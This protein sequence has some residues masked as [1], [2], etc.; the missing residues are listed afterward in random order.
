M[1]LDS[2]VEQSFVARVLTKYGQVIE[3]R[4]CSYKDFPD[5]KNG[6]KQ[7]RMILKMEIPCFIFV[8]SRRGHVRYRGQPRTCFRCGVGGHEAK[9]CVN[10]R[11]NICLGLGHVRKDCTND[12]VVCSVCGKE[13]H[14]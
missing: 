9:S 5:V 6:T 4:Y 1:Y 14:V 12:P 2:E 11:C 13:G 8:G 3:S 7:F 10:V